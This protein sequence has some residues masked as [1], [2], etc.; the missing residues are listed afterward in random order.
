MQNTT[1][2]AR[3][4]GQ[5]TLTRPI[6]GYM[7]LQLPEKKEYYPSLIKLNTGRNCLEY[8]IKT[9]GYTHIYLP[10][11]TCEVL[12]EPIRNQGIQYSFYKI[13]ANLDPILDFEIGE[14]Q[15][16]VYTNYFGLKQRTVSRLSKKV[17]N[18]IVDNSQ[19]FFS[20]PVPG[21]D[22]FYSCR[23][24]FGVSD[25]AYLQLNSNERLNLQDDISVNRFSHLIKSIDLG[26]ESGYGD[27]VQN[28]IDFVDKPVKNMSALTRKILASLDYEECRKRRNA[29]FAFLDYFLKDS[30]SLKLDF[31]ENDAPLVYPLLVSGNE[32]KQQLIERKIFVPTFWPNVFNWAERD[33]FEYNLA[34]NLISLPIDHRYNLD[35]MTRMLNIIN[36][37]L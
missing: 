7:E 5:S 31:S 20:H 2:L 9:K 26:I 19:A 11:F 8:I 14:K 12:L 35:D 28:N 4:S 24:F 22:T 6:G 32:L 29:N 16:F 30:N 37:L 13:D 36:Q 25:G 3:Q 1:E 10:Y 27:F 21:V 18:L 17:K 33:S 15:G 34:K 23:K